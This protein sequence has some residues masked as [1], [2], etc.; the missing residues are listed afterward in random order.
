MSCTKSE[1]C[2]SNVSG[3]RFNYTEKT[4]IKNY[5]EHLDDLICES[6]AK[7]KMIPAAFYITGTLSMAL[8]P[9]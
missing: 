3:Y 5:Y 6:T 4:S 2:Q 8:A 1:V 9:L 7:K